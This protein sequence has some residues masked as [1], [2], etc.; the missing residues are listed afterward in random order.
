MSERVRLEPARHIK[1]QLDGATVAES[2]RGFVVFETGLPPRYYVPRADVRAQLADG[3]GAGTCPWKGQWKHLDV[4]VGDK[5]I[6]NGAWTYYE[7]KP[8]TEPVRDF[9]AFYETK[10]AIESAGSAGDA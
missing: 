2:D 6:A 4:V 1:I 10:F 8:V 3:T 7:M 9:V 5:R